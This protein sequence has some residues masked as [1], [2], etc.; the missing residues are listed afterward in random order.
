MADYAQIAADLALRYAGTVVRYRKS[1][2]SLWDTVLITDVI[3]NPKA[4]PQLMLKGLAG[5]QL[6]SYGTEGEFNFEFPD[7]GCFNYNGLGLAFFRRPS[8]QNKRALC[9]ATSV[10]SN[11]YTASRLTTLPGFDIFMANAMFNR[12]YTPKETALM[13]LNART[14]YCIAINSEFMLGLN[15][16]EDRS[17][18]LFHRI[19]PIAE[20][21]VSGEVS[22]IL[23][24]A[25]EG[26]VY[27][28][29]S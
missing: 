25:F 23:H 4:L 26:K 6:I 24:P 1:S 20:I 8:R 9:A 15:T 18:L 3:S 12:T 28:Y 13:H 5:T 21:S 2:D 11:H 7:T 19:T 17:H 22:S 10:R 14:T 27:E 29:L 16:R